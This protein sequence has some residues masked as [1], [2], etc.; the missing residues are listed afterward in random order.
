[1]IKHT[2]NEEFKH[3][4]RL[5]LLQV[6]LALGQY[7]QG[8]QIIAEIDPAKTEGFSASYDELQGDL[9]VAMGRQDEA[10]NAY[11]SALRNDQANPL[12]QFKLDDLSMPA[13]TEAVSK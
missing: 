7:E 3:I 6:L 9:Y 12:L 10:R 5:R 11:Q 1:L 8:L 13:P 2:G 4:A